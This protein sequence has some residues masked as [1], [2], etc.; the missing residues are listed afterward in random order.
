MFVYNN[1]I[2]WLHT[3]KWGLAAPPLSAPPLNLF[4]TLRLIR[5]IVL[6][7]IFVIKSDD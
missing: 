1:V 2:T 6:I 7:D 3:I 4:S 5:T